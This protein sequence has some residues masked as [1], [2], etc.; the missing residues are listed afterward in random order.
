MA[1]VE[2]LIVGCGVAGPTLATFLLLISDVPPAQKPHITVVERASERVA[3]TRGQNIDV[4]GAGVAVLRQLGIERL[5]RR[6][7][8]GEEGVRLVDGRDRV[9]AQSATDRTGSVQTPTADIEILRGRLSEICWR[10]SLRVCADVEQEEGGR[11]IEYI[12]GDYV[13]ELSQ[14]DGD[15]V[16]VR[17]AKSGVRRSFD[18]V[19]GAD[20]LH[21]RTRKLVWGEEGEADRIKRLGMYAGFFSIPREEKTDDQWRR[22]FHAP[23][24][25]GVMLR[26]DGTGTRTTVLLSVVKSVEEENQKMADLAAMGHA[27]VGSQKAMLEEHFCDAG[28]E[29]ERVLR[30]MKTTDDFYFDMVAQVKMDKW[31]KGRVVLLGDA[32]YCASPVSGLG[33]TL[34]FT[35]AYNLAGCLQEFIK[36]TTPDP[37]PALAEYEAKMRPVV[38]EAQH[39]APGQA[40]L[41]HPET[42]LG[43]RM[44]HLFASFVLNVKLLFTLLGKLIPF[45]PQMA[46]DVP[47]EDYRFRTVP[48]WEL[49]DASFEQAKQE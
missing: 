19:V 38:E 13:E 36:G 22:W 18:L 40:Y 11:G 48:E 7:T 44:L 10:N 37:S 34:A 21:S 24:R 47:L 42:A 32:G 43:I 30:E 26:P 16:R 28:W 41:M 27:G 15:K 39:L 5:V 45:G 2:I 49:E 20:G 33:T 17:F 1:P 23:G 46:N 12:F 35:A 8:T 29:C 6:S 9:W 4:R 3:H 31:S 14:E 25:R